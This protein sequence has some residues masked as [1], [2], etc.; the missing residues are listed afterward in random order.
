MRFNLTANDAM[1]T[2]VVC[3]NSSASTVSML[4]TGWSGVRI[5]TCTTDSSLL[6]SL[7]TASEVHP[8]SYSMCTGDFFPGI[9]ERPRLAADYFFTVPRFKMHRDYLHSPPPPGMTL[10]GVQWQIYLALPTS[11][12]YILGRCV[13]RTWDMNER[14]E[15]PEIFQVVFRGWQGKKQ[16]N[17]KGYV[18]DIEQWVW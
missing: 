10:W 12:L 16:E 11:S 3:R 6:Q 4:R 1:E 9:V 14:S 7:Q 15:L 2:D 13:I 18:S 17:L 8:V 5:L